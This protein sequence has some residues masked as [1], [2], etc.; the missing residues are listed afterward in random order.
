MSSRELSSQSFMSVTSPGTLLGNDP[1]SASSSSHISSMTLGRC[2]CILHLSWE[3]GCSDS[4]G[5]PLSPSPAWQSWLPS[6]QS[7]CLVLCSRHV[8][9]S[10]LWDYV[11]KPYEH[12][13]GVRRG[14]YRTTSSLTSPS[15]IL[16]WCLLGQRRQSG[17]DLL[18]LSVGT[19]VAALTMPVKSQ[20]KPW[21][22][23]SVDL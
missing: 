9:P 11:L 12:T 8:S 17:M 4:G 2:L 20:E 21:K 3:Q 13:S 22:R 19:Y 16:I 14:A 5:S 1:M 6:W 10:P 18:L 7:P 15:N 23:L